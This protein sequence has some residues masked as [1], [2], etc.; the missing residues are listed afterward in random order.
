MQEPC[1]REVAERASISRVALLS[2]HT[3]PLD[4]PGIGDSGGMNVYVRQ[5]SRRLAE[6][7]VAV[8]VFTRASDDRQGISEV[9]P[10]VRVIHLEAGPDRP[11]PKEELADHLCEFLY[12]LLRFE[13]GEAARLGAAGPIYDVVH[14]NYWLSG[15]VG[16]RLRERWGIPLVQSFHTLGRV[17]NLALVDGDRPEP[18]YRIANEERIVQSADCVLAPTQ[19]EARDLVRLYAAH[20]DRVRVVSPGVDTALFRPAPDREAARRALDVPGRTLVLFVG[21]LQP[22]KAPDLA[23]RAVAE[24]AAPGSALDP[25]LLIVGGP[26]GGSAMGPDQIARIAADEGIPDRVVVHEPVPQRRLA[27]FYRAAD[28]VILPSRS[29]S[30]GLVALEAS[31]SGTPVVATDV[32]GLRTTVRD[33]ETGILVSGAD[34]APFAGA[35]RRILADQA[36]ATAMA[37]AGPRF[38]ARFD[39]R[40]AAA[41]LLSVYRERAAAANR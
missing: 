30:F 10:G 23:V 18:A 37:H 5:V 2:V 24:L 22:L 21:R 25:V 38:A 26:S 7:G 33:G 19:D 13:A 41:G 39:W 35:M 14:S 31:A 17:K 4:Q 11:I 28:V 32:G 16:R 1:E 27:D 6:S 8:D 40:H 34:P 36:L 3:C 15:W 12:A 9:D 20:P 29:E